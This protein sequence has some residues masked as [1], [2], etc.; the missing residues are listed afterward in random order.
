MALGLGHSWIVLSWRRLG[1]LGAARS[2]VLESGQSVRRC[3]HPSEGA[4][5]LFEEGALSLDGSALPG[6]RWRRLLQV[7]H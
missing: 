5:I 1:G 2:L 4:K 7:F 6:H 3:R